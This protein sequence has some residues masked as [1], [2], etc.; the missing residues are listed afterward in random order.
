MIW[1]RFRANAKQYTRAKAQCIY[2]DN[3]NDQVFSHF[4]L[5]DVKPHQRYISD[6]S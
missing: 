5:T 6:T 4:L 1:D 2:H 3:K